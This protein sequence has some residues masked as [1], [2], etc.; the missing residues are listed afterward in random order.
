MKRFY[1]KKQKEKTIE[2]YAA[3][4]P[5]A[6]IAGQTGVSKSSVSRIAVSAGLKLRTP[7]K[8]KGQTKKCAFC[9][10]TVDSNFRFCPYC[11]RDVRS[12]DEIIIEQLHS[13]YDLLSLLPEG[14][15]DEAQ[16]VINKA[17]AYIGGAKK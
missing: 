2:L 14:S 4:V 8:K 3:G 15:R 17:V 9:G 12:E 11:G 7:K 10:A 5:V 13:L 1:T 16:N 6:E